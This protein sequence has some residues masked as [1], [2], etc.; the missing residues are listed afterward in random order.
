MTG[1]SGCLHQYIEFNGSKKTKCF[2][3]FL[4]QVEFTVFSVLM[5]GE[6]NYNIQGMCENVFET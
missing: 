5:N 2:L 6:K 4:P 3:K 1:C